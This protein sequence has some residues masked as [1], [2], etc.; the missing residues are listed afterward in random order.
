MVEMEQHWWQHAY[1]YAARILDG[2]AVFADA[3]PH[4]YSQNEV[5][6]R[7]SWAEQQGG[8]LSVVMVTSRAGAI[9]PRSRG[10][11]DSHS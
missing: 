11:D 7:N 6:S 4:C 5:S 2:S 3:D 10:S 8:L 9:L 1:C